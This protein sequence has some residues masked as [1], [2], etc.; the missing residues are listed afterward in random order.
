MNWL[1]LVKILILRRHKVVFV[2]HVGK[3]VGRIVKEVEGTSKG[4][5]LTLV[6]EGWVVGVCVAE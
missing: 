2:D 3:P 6:C 4:E 1:Y 5:A